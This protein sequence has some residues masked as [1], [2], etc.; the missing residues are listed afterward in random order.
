MINHLGELHYIRVCNGSVPY[1]LLS[2]DALC[3]LQKNKP[4]QHK[5]DSVTDTQTFFDQFNRL[6][7]E[8]D[9]DILT[10]D[11]LKA[12]V[13]GM[14][15]QIKHTCFARAVK[16][17]LGNSDDKVLFVFMA[18][19]FVE[20]ADDYISINDIDDLYDDGTPRRIKYLLRDQSSELFKVNFIENVNEDGM[21][22]PDRFKLTDKA[23]YEV[24]SELN[25]RQVG[26][27]EKGLIKH[28]TLAEKQLVYNASEKKQITELSAILSQERFNDV[29]ARLR[30][31]GMRPGFCCLF[32]GAPGTGKTETVYQLARQTGRNILR[33]D[34]DKIKSCWV[35][36]SEKNIKRLF[37]RYRNLC[38]NSPLAPILLS[39]CS[40]KRMP[41]SV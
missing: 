34:V 38:Q 27:S 19:L 28:D 23:K 26:I 10:Y 18:H 25:F 15:N 24:L 20:N 17:E 35:D 41:C 31:A 21:V 33:V 8:K 30:V 4:Y 1:Y 7:K 22:R 12:E 5:Q 29:Q 6:T 39:C 32:Y 40:T 11:N 9:D 14:L 16:R 37:D 36:E 13:F 2:Q 3:A